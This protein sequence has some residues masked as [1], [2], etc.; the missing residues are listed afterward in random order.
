M[1]TATAIN[2]DQTGNVVPP[3]AGAGRHQRGLPRVG[4]PAASNDNRAS[5]VRL[6]QYYTRPDIARHFYAIFRQHFDPMSYQMVEPSAGTGAF[7]RLM[8]IGS[9]AYDVEPRFPGIRTAD[10]LEVSLDS[11]REVAIIVTVRSCPPCG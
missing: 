5:D 3:T 11:D 1:K 6:D 4:K 2:L 10:F 9:L 7:F 8:P